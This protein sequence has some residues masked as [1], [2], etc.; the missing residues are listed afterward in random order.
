VNILYRPI[1]RW[2]RELTRTR[3]RSPF[4]A[5]YHATIR[6]LETELRHANARTPVVQLALGEDQF[7]VSDGK[8]YANATPAHP[9]VLL[10]FEKG[11]RTPMPLAFP[12]DAYLTW[13]ENLRAIALALDAL[14]KVDRYGVTKHAEQYRGWNAL[15]P[16][17]IT[18]I[19][20][21]VQQA[22]E[23]IAN[24]LGRPGDVG[25]VKG[26]ADYYR[27]TYR[28]AAQRWHPDRNQ[29]VQHPEWNQL[30][31]AKAVLDAHHGT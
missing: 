21:D 9:G 22:A 4:K 11:S 27:A 18:P 8:P 3:K 26:L 25:R 10:S 28:E 31:T 16:S 20:M 19:A 30:Q 29:G 24:Q 15:P 2:P 7:R 13:I 6:L 14:R 1:E 5:A 12:C 23:F 17:I